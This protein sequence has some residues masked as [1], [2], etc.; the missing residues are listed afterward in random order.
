[1]LAREGKAQEAIASF[2]RASELEPGNAT[3]WHV[4]GI[5]HKRVGDRTAAREAFRHAR[6]LDPRRQDT[7]RELESLDR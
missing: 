2:H 4:L 7:A 6:D 1:V 5:L 3:T